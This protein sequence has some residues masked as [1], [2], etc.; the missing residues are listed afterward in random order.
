MD[1]YQTYALWEKEETNY[2]LCLQTKKYNE[3]ILL[4][5][6]FMGTLYYIY[7]Y[8]LN[9]QKLLIVSKLHNKLFIF[10]MNKIINKS[11]I[12]HI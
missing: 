4:C 11:Y 2:K 6:M 9:L 7:F 3:F 1:L 5:Q 12:N 10:T 8:N